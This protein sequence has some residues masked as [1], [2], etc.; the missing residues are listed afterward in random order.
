MKLR[1]AA[2]IICIAFL[3]LALFTDISDALFLPLSL[4]ALAASNVSGLRLTLAGRNNN[5]S[6]EL[7]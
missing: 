1:I 5:S 3:A 2:L 7:Q 4:A 6:K